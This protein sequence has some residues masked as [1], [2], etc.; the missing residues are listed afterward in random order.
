MN[1]KAYTILLLLYR[2]GE[3]QQSLYCLQP[4]IEWVKLLNTA[5]DIDMSCFCNEYT[6]KRTQI[7]NK[8]FTP[9]IDILGVKHSSKDE[10]TLKIKPHR[11][12]SRDIATFWTDD[13]LKLRWRAAQNTIVVTMV[14][15]LQYVFFV[16]IHLK[17]KRSESS[18]FSLSALIYNIRRNYCLTLV[19]KLVTIFQNF[20]LMLAICKKFQS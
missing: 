3:Q 19:S 11:L 17:Q 18:T 10:W 2:S 1:S 9:G 8:N 16:A 7:S 12:C 20:C 4:H 13:W 6:Q 5:S 14:T 15:F